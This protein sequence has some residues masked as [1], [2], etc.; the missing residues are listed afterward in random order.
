MS[1]RIPYDKPPLTITEQLQL[2][3]DRGLIINNESKALH[4]LENLSYYRLSGYWYPFLADRV[5]HRFKLNASFE[6]AFQLYCFDKELRKL[7]NSELEKIE[8]A[9]RAKIIYILSHDNDNP[10]WFEDSNL[11]NNYNNSHNRLLDKITSE[12]ERSDQ[13]F[14]RAFKRKYINSLPPSWITMEVI[15]FGTLSLLYKNLKNGRSK[16]NVAKYFG[17]DKQTFTSWIHCLVYIRNICAHHSRLWNRTLGIQPRIPR[18]PRKQWL[19]TPPPNN[20]KPFFVLSM[21]LYLLQTI[22]PQSTFHK[23]FKQLSARY[24]DVEL[25]SLGFP[26]NWK[27]E[28]LWKDGS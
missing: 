1:D 5:D 26:L 24:S 20:N 12:Y 28:P 9:V 27:S 8:V 4:L 17:L 16:R 22:N 14:I 25:T 3:R 7:V 13:E 18:T 6:N 23:R 15:S 19:D 10:F 21:I 11:F 2:L